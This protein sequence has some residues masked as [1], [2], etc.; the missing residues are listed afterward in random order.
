MLT[1]IEDLTE[2]GPH[3]VC[4]QEEETGATP[5]HIVLDKSKCDLDIVKDM[6]CANADV[7]NVQDKKGRLPLHLAAKAEISFKL[8]KAMVKKHPHSIFCEDSEGDIPYTIAR[9]AHQD[10]EIVKLLKPPHDHHHR[11]Q[12]DSV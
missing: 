6:I 1:I 2:V 4:L 10:K 12:N 8:I 5:L 7:L 11:H 3:A 9:S